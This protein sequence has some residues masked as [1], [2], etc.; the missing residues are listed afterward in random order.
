VPEFPVEDQL[1]SFLSYIDYGDLYF[2]V[3]DTPVQ[4]VPSK[5]DCTYIETATGATLD[6]ERVEIFK[7]MYGWDFW[8]YRV[9]NEMMASPKVQDFGRGLSPRHSQTG[10]LLTTKDILTR[11]CEPVIGSYEWYEPHMAEIVNQVLEEGCL[12][13]SSL[14]EH[15]NYT[16][17]W[18]FMM[19][20]IMA[21]AIAAAAYLKSPMGLKLLSYY[22]PVYYEILDWD[23]DTDQPKVREGTGGECILYG[24]TPYTLKN[25]TKQ[26]AVPAGTCRKCSQ[27]LHCTKLL[28]AN[29]LIWKVCSCGSLLDPADPNR[30]SSHYGASCKD[31]KVKHPPIPSFVCFRC[32]ELHLKYE[33]ISEAPPQLKCSRTA[34]PNTTCAHHMGEA[35]RRHELNQRRKLMLTQSS[36]S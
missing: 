25:L 6:P 30:S 16:G 29:A 4:L 27:T 36:T 2:L 33:N 22:H 31:A 19:E 12:N 14:D 10:A 1:R 34:C 28:D 20:S 23:Y 8:P 15:S 17:V 7:V 3:T 18:D 32:T 26:E 35:Y 13:A 21:V 9:F 24:A 11:L 5:M